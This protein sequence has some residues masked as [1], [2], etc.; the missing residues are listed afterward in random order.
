[1][2]SFV[3]FL[4]FYRLKSVEFIKNIKMPKAYLH[5]KA[6]NLPNTDS[7]GTADPYFKVYFNDLEL[8]KSETADAIDY[9]DFKPAEFEIPVAALTRHCLVRFFDKDLLSKDESMLDLEI[10]YPFRRKKYLHEATKAQISICDK[11]GNETNSSASETSGTEV[12][13]DDENE[14]RNAERAKRREVRAAKQKAR[15]KAR[16]KEMG[17]TILGFFSKD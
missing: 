1:M 4:I 6:R 14:M 7:V 2:G 17:K 8:Y 3:K 11:D 12:S 10:R 13:E 15:R 5:I 9:V 16:K